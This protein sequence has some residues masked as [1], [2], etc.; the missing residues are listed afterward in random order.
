MNFN[1]SRCFSGE[2]CENFDLFVRFSYEN[3]SRSRRR[4]WS[5]V[6]FFKGAMLLILGGLTL[7]LQA[8]APV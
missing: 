3:R 1:S 4:A 6:S 7:S 5:M 8:P 2:I